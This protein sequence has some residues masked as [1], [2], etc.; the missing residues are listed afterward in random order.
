MKAEQQADATIGALISRISPTWVFSSF[1]Q[2]LLLVWYVA[3]SNAEMQARI[4]TVENWM[5][6]NDQMVVRVTRLETKMD[7]IESGLDRIEKKIDRF[8]EK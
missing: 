5:R 3:T 2:A 1:L 6:S 8:T 7:G 4:G